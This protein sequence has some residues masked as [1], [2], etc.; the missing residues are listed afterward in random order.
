MKRKTALSPLQKSLLIIQAVLLVLTMA[1]CAGSPATTTPAA[2]APTTSTTSPS[3]TTS[4]SQTAATTAAPTTATSATT[5]AAPTVSGPMSADD[6]AADIGGTLYTMLGPVEGL[7]AFLGQPVFFSEAP[8]CL[9]EGTDKTYEYEDLIL[10]TITKGGQD[11]ID[12]IDL[13]TDRWTTRR[14]IRVGSTVEDVLEAYG[15]PFS[16]DPDLV[17]ISD[18]TLGEVSPR[19]TFVINDGQVSMVSIY[20]GSNSADN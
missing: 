19:I 13:A 5:T 3:P 1:A 12:G 6:L 14:G 9:Y 10:Y 15:D 4:V 20:S 7:L 11:L 2:T 17:Y 8:S 16:E 18:Q